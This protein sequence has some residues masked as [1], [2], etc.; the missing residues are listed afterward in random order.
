MKDSDDWTATKIATRSDCSE[1]VFQTDDEIKRRG[2]NDDDKR[3]ADDDTEDRDDWTASKMGTLS[4]CSE[5]DD[6]Y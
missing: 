2:Q 5:A 1:A 6:K 3:K 4:D